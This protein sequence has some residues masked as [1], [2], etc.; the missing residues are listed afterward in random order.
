M[1]VDLV[2]IGYILL[3]TTY[4]CGSITSCVISIVKIGFPMQFWLHSL[5]PLA[6]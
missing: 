1:I 2:D 6:I 3:A 5:I 4:T